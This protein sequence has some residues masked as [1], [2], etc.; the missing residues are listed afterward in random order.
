M[1]KTFIS[2]VV[3]LCG[4]LSGTGLAQGP[5]TFDFNDQFPVVDESTGTLT[6]TVNRSGG[7]SGTVTVNYATANGT[8]IA[9]SD[10]TATSGTV[11]FNTGQATKTFTVPIINDGAFENDED[12]TVT[13][14][15]P[16]SGAVLGAATVAFVTITSDDN[17]DNFDD[18]QLIAGVADEV[19]GND[20]IATSEGEF[21]DNLIPVVWF[22]WVAP[23]TGVVR[24]AVPPDNGH[25]VDIFRGTTYGNK[26]SL[27]GNSVAPSLIA[28]PPLRSA[29]N[30]SVTAGTT[31]H[32]AVGGGGTD[33][34]LSWQ[35]TTNGV[36]SL[37]GTQRF[38]DFLVTGVDADRFVADEKGGPI[39]VKVRRTGG[40]DGVV[41][42]TY[43]VRA[44]IDGIFG[45]PDATAGSDFTA[46]TGTVTFQPG[47]AE[48]T[49]TVAIL[50]DTNDEGDEDFVITLSNP[51]GGAL[52]G[53]DIVQAHLLEDEND[54]A[55][56][57]F[58]SAQPIF[59]SAGTV[60]GDNSFAD[61]E[62]TEPPLFFDGVA[63]SIQ[64]FGSTLWYRWTPP[65]SGV[66]EFTASINGNPES[67]LIDIYTSGAGGL[68][69]VKHGGLAYDQDFNGVFTRAVF[70][71]T[72][73]QVYYV[74]I[75]GSLLNGD[76]GGTEL[77]WT[78]ATGG[79][80]N[81]GTQTFTV[82]EA[83][84][85]AYQVVISR[86]GGLTNGAAVTLTTSDN[87]ADSFGDYTA[88][89]TTVVFNPGEATKTV[90][91][92]ILND[93]DFE[94]DEFF[95]LTLLDA[96]G[97]VLGDN[98]FATVTLFDD[99]DD[100]TNDLFIARKALVGTSG[101]ESAT[102][103]GA[104]SEPDEP[105]HGRFSVWYRWTSPS[106]PQGIA[107]FG[108]NFSSSMPGPTVT[109]YTGTAVN[110]LAKV[111]QGTEQVA[112][113]PTPNTTY[114]I[115]I[116]DRG[117]DDGLGGIYFAPSPFDLTYDFSIG[118]SI[119][120]FT[121]PTMSVAETTNT[122]TVSLTRSGST[123]G[124]ATVDFDLVDTTTTV[125][126]E[127]YLYAPGTVTFAPG[128]AT[129][130]FT[131]G[132]L[133]DTSLEGDESFTVYLTNPINAVLGGT[134]PLEA[135]VTILD[136]EDDVIPPTNDN[137]AAAVLLA[138]NNPV[139]TGFTAGATVEAN[140]P[141]VAGTAPNSSVWFQWVAPGN[142]AARLSLSSATHF[143]SAY[144]GSTLANLTEATFVSPGAFTVT[145]GTT[146]FVPVNATAGSTFDLTI[147]FSAAGLLSFSS[148]SLSVREDAGP[149]AITILRTNG[150]SGAVSVRF[151]AIS[152]TAQ[153]GSDFTA[154]DTVV[155][156]G[157]GVG[158]QTVNVPVANDALEE[159][160]ETVQLILSDATGGAITAY[161]P[162][163]LVT[164]LIQDDETAPPNDNFAAAIAL[165]G[166][167]GT[168]F[169]SNIDGT[170]EA[171]EPTHA[172]AG[173]GAS[174]W[175]RWTAPANGTVTFQ[176][177]GSEIP[178]VLAAYS[179]SAVNALNAV[180]SSAV[181]PSSISFTA[182][183]G[184]SYALAVDGAG[185]TR[186]DVSLSWNLLLPGVISF[187]PTSYAVNESGT[188]V[189]LTVVRAI[190]SDGTV[191]VNFT[192]AD[193]SAVAGQDYTATSGTLTF[194][195]G[196]T[197]KTITVPITN[198]TAFETVESF[199]VVL[200]TPTGG[201]VIDVAT[202]TV[203]V[204]SNDAFV[205]S[206]VKF[207]ALVNTGGAHA[208]SGLVTLTV[209]ANAGFSGSLT[210]G[211]Q[212]DKFTGGFDS[213]GK[214]LVRVPR[215]G[216]STVGL[217]I[218]ITDGGKAI[219]GRVYDNTFDS[220][221]SGDASFFS[222]TN[223]YPGAGAY[224]LAL[225]PTANGATIP[226]GI[227]TAPL[228]VGPDGII[229]IKKG[230]LA[231]G[232]ELKGTL[233][234]IAQNG[235]VQF[236]KALYKGAGSLSGVVTFRNETL[237]DADGTL[238]WFKPA[239]VPKIL[240]VPGFTTNLALEAS[241][242]VAPAKDTRI[243]TAFNANAGAT[244][245]VLTSG[246]LATPVT[247]TGALTTANALTAT[248]P[249]PLSL[250]SKTKEGAFNGKFT[251]TG[252]SET[253]FTGVFL[254]KSNKAVGQFLGL[255]LSG[256]VQITPTP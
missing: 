152:L 220:A 172:G 99:E 141:T 227:G 190:G 161:A 232:S 9:G 127:D 102:T 63:G 195:G 185:A 106:G 188:N 18:A 96:T 45:L 119:I 103:E 189:V 83:V 137:F 21:E 134:D 76:L 24:F 131:V 218:Q 1:K 244:T 158:S 78:T 154:V 211:G 23:I 61:V 248:V 48:K 114:I 113:A 207:A 115:A 73:G 52:L 53:T 31:Y 221:L 12:F 203:N 196:E 97:G 163:Q 187:S 91:I 150:T 22:R 100:P 32:I 4:V 239:N 69:L 75:D 147:N 124:T 213:F 25:F 54:P 181:N 226:Q 174:I 26:V 145:A 55:N 186:G 256:S 40:L 62:A 240:F 81:F 58:A 223:V 143:T 125:A 142:G 37:A 88:V 41:A 6:L 208:T 230:V 111:I 216:K 215:K 51:T 16:S 184:T 202:A 200:S 50:N 49:F 56:D 104:G 182:V 14:S 27:T 90:S 30:A 85:A 250:T 13:L 121:N 47:E 231:D 235:K 191:T 198:D 214:A 35:A 64:A 249:I 59:G 95:D 253:K 160:A 212:A 118:G 169:G 87:S 112:F 254:Q 138:G 162:D 177:T 255:T 94:G 74:R 166:P 199:T 129:K 201:A 178:T 123:T 252:G 72:A 101:V 149:A 19:T 135:S 126:G 206:A 77:T 157:N 71:A 34:T 2:I 175:F 217:E 247:V 28:F 5:G 165:S 156:F 193:G 245:I 67:G 93:F 107:T 7:T 168:T 29:V 109:V 146:Y 242:Y 180:A 60:L 66:A 86:E 183:A 8:A 36:L 179:G 194:A 82:T 204:T 79:V 225:S 234:F 140:E 151:R 251:P 144:T 238:A 164:L 139:V 84:G 219:V 132:I 153:S 116:T 209:S 33:F 246:G 136:D 241:R 105:D 92:P 57:D 110:A 167:F 159:G 197:T 11:T 236:Y 42:V 229:S 173:A 148:A 38:N 17:N 122:L 3:A 233:G 68:Q 133:D 128:E 43:Q 224:T 108:L 44:D 98:T 15:S 237:T 222:K 117:G 170:A 192:T 39:T 228:T 46:A 171:G 20:A 70:Q 80:I 155:N 10:Y 89:N 243:D 176:T 65:A 210:L 205:A 120:S 130:T